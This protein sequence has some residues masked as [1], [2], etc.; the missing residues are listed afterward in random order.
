V[1]RRDREIPTRH[2]ID[3]VIR[4]ATVCHL[5]FAVNNEPYVVPISF[6]YDGEALYIHTARTGKKIN[7]IE[8][9]NRV[10]F[11][12]EANVRLQADENDACSWTFTFESV[13]GYGT[14]AEL[15][16]PEAKAHGLNRIMEHY[17]G[18]EWE[19]SVEALA[20]TR[21]WRIAVE[22][23]TGKRSAEKPSTGE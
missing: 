11:E 20:T 13:I 10:C 19:M 18:R 6:G 4:A 3:A 5:G 1:R 23:I 17:S 16:T 14:V 8:R 22:E 15:T 9:N 12:L 21:V 2:E 7:C